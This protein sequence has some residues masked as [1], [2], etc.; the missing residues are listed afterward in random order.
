MGHEESVRSDGRWFP[1]QEDT[2]WQQNNH[3]SHIWN[4][5]YSLHIAA[6]HMLTQFKKASLIQM[7]KHQNTLTSPT[8]GRNKD[9]SRLI[10][11]CG[12]V[13]NLLDHCKQSL[14]IKKLPAPC[15]GD[16]MIFIP[17]QYDMLTYIRKYEHCHAQ[18]DEDTNERDYNLHKW[19]YHNNKWVQAQYMFYK[20]SNSIRPGCNHDQWYTDRITYFICFDIHTIKDWKRPQLKFFTRNPSESNTQ[21]I[22]SM[23]QV[24]RMQN[25]MHLAIKEHDIVILSQPICHVYR[26]TTVGIIDPYQR[27]SN[28]VDVSHSDA[29]IKRTYGVSET[30]EETLPFHDDNQFI[31]IYPIDT[32]CLDEIKHFLNNKQLNAALI[33]A[34]SCHLVKDISL[35]DES[36][37]VALNDHHEDVL[38]YVEPILWLVPHPIHLLSSDTTFDVCFD[39]TQDN[40]QICINQQ[41]NFKTCFTQ[42]VRSLKDKNHVWEHVKFNDQSYLQSTS[43]LH[44]QYQ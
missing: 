16:V 17:E 1:T 34:L 42:F 9:G 40:I 14:Q 13:D 6:T 31:S 30:D 35:V 22:A 27:E 44:P 37:L 3:A 15:E 28:D 18:C 24:V 38:W 41:S 32:D 2:K 19:H 21:T 8:L 11:T 26:K 36:K 33:N 12:C 39:D 4:S 20:H 29:F 5:D 10:K 43:Y 7:L 25:R 23:L